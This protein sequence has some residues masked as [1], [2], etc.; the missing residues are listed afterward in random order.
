LQSAIALVQLDQA[1]RRAI[2]LNIGGRLDAAVAQQRSAQ[3][4][5]RAANWASDAAGHGQAW[6]AGGNHAML[7]GVGYSIAVLLFG[8]PCG[9]LEVDHDLSLQF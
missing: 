2:G 3:A 7:L 8:Y 1:G 6:T 9:D 5:K 4:H